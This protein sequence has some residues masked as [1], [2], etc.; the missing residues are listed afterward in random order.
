MYP[1]VKIEHKQNQECYVCLQHNEVNVDI[2]Y[3]GKIDQHKIKA[4]LTPILDK[5]PN[6]SVW[7]DS[8]TTLGYLHI[9]RINKGGGTIRAFVKTHSEC[10]NPF[11]NRKTYAMV[12][13]ETTVGF[14][15]VSI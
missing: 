4:V 9:F 5:H 3:N 15:S 7:S 12:N 10:N 6:I 11:S 14:D 2:L 8:S 13:P 1:Y